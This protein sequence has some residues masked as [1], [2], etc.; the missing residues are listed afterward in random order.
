MTVATRYTG[1]P[2]PN[3]GYQR[4]PLQVVRTKSGREIV[5]ID[6]MV[7]VELREDYRRAGLS[8]PGEHR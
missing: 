4:S 2:D 3:P 6:A 1:K 7:L 5:W 8:W